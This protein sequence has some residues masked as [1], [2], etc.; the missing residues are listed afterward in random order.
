MQRKF[1]INCNALW[2]TILLLLYSS[3][4]A[5]ETGKIAGIIIDKTSKEPVAGANI[6]INTVWLENLEV[7]MERPLGAA[8]DADGVFYIINITPGTYNVYVSFVGYI[9]EV[10]TKVQV[11]VDKTTTVDFELTPE[12]LSTE[13]IFVSAYRPAEVEKDLTAT[14][15]TY[16]INSLQ[17][18]AGMT[19]IGSVLSLQADVVGDH[20]RGGRS[21]EAIYLVG[22]AS[23]VNPLNNQRSFDPITTG[24]EQVEVYTS[25]FSA[26]Y[27]NVQSGV[28]N[29]IPKEG[30]DKWRTRLEA[31]S[32]NSYYKTHGG[33]IYSTENLSFY[34]SM[35]DINEWLDGV[36]PVS[37]RVLWQYFGLNFPDNY[38]V[39][40]V[41]D[42]KKCCQR[43]Y[44]QIEIPFS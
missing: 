19:D 11:Y 16:D 28:V 18:I 8:S 33:S 22:G 32:T 29:M 25:G 36:D 7:T 10:K 5:G 27:G 9:D 30:K 17:N 31:A 39:V 12:I 3:L 21:G 23:I 4:F 40:D 14:K 13:T 24:L 44:N 43:P 35:I 26:E 37:G 1:K 34:S 2:L 42:A 38:L 41:S 6:V 20:F 15:T